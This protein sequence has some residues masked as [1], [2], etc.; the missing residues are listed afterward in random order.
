MNPAQARAA[1]REYEIEQEDLNEHYLQEKI[2][3]DK[4]SIRIRKAVRAVMGRVAGVSNAT[5]LITL[6]KSEIKKIIDEMQSPET[7]ELNHP[8]VYCVWETIYNS[9]HTLAD[10]ELPN[11]AEHLS[12][13][14]RTLEKNT[15]REF[16]HISEEIALIKDKL[17][18]F[19]S[20]KE[21]YNVKGSIQIQTSTMSQAESISGSINQVMERMPTEHEIAELFKSKGIYA[22][23][24]PYDAAYFHSNT[25][26]AIIAIAA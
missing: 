19:R 10:F 13:M 15:G 6:I 16:N 4:D 22:F 20:A 17:R 12:T 21:S 14:R 2:R 1:V 9:L 8:E 3:R 23:V 5:T 24:K 7:G 11:R 25:T 18:G 26:Y